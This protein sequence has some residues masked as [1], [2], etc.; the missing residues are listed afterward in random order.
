M[1]FLHR[2]FVAPRAARYSPDAVP[3]AILT[4]SSPWDQ[5]AIAYA[6]GQTFYASLKVVRIKRR[7]QRVPF[8]PDSAA[9]H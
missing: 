1:P 5:P 8:V 9:F 3:L 4:G 2:P 6:N 7:R